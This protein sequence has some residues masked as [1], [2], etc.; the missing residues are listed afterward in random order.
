M[1]KNAAFSRASPAFRPCFRRAG[2]VG[3][4]LN[5]PLQP[6]A[7]WLQKRHHCLIPPTHFAGAIPL[8]DQ[9]NQ[10]VDW[11]CA[12]DYVAHL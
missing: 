10:P 8:A 9:Q 3:R 5:R 2:R 12:S 6:S 11:C 7:R 1:V 4:K